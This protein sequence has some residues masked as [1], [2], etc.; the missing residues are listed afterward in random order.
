MN[1]IDEI[2]DKIEKFDYQFKIAKICG[3]S[4]D[5]FQRKALI[6]TEPTVEEAKCL[7]L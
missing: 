5:L 2:L 7:G 3:V 4:C 6:R 1:Q